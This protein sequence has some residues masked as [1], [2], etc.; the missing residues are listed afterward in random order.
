MVV[1]SG[2]SLA[3]IFQALISITGMTCSSCVGKITAALEA[4][5]W[6]HSVNVSLLTNSASVRFEGE[7][8]TKE[9]A[10]IIDSISYEATIEQAGK[11]VTPERTGSRATSNVWRASYTIRG[12]TCSSCIGNI[13]KALE[14]YSWIRIVDINLI[15]NNATIVFEGKGRLGEIQDAIEDVGYKAK[16]DNI[17]DMSRD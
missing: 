4:K 5:S 7:D 11:I 14:G 8:C 9:L 12:M 17:V 1:D 2:F 16:L 3:K 10:D 13:I 6:V 15:T